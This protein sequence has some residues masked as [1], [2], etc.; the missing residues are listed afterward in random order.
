MKYEIAATLK[1][2]LKITIEADS[3]EEALRIAEY[4]LITEDFDIVTAE[5]N[6]GDVTE[7]VES[8]CGACGL[9]IGKEEQD[10]QGHHREDLCGAN[11][12][13]RG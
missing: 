10:T 5:F 11:D 8:N 7:I 1:Q 6:L 3:Y 4:D 2:D 13:I 9:F 12:E